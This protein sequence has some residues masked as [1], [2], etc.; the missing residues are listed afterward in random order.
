M[1]K[2]ATDVRGVIS[3]FFANTEYTYR[4]P[5]DE[6]DIIGESLPYP[7]MFALNK[8]GTKRTAE[9]DKDILDG[10]KRAGFKLDFGIDGSGIA[11]FYFT[12]GGGYYIDVGCSKLIIDGKIKVHQSPKGISGFTGDALALQDGNELKA[13]IVVLATGYD[14]MKTTAQKIMG[15]KVAARLKDVWDLDEEGELNAVSTNFMDIMARLDRMKPDNSRLRCG[16]RVAILISGIWVATSPFA[17][18]TP[19]TSHYRLRPTKRG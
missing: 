6:C 10:L 7:V 13:D 16:D 3:Y 4:P 14:N 17:G 19:S 5:T 12:R 1:G 15:D 18:F 2:L 11:R 8:E 9:A